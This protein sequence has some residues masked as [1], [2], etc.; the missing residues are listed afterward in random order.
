MIKTF[1]EIEVDSAGNKYADKIE[2]SNYKLF[3][4]I[5]ATKDA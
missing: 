2:T 5:T 3:Q 4:G 1:L